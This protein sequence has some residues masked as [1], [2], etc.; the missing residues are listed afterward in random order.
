VISL[1]NELI[2]KLTT[3]L[4]AE[5][6]VEHVSLFGSRARG[7]NRENSDI[8]LAL[9]GREIPLSLYT[10]LRDSVGLYK[11]D[12]VNVEEVDNEDLLEEIQTHGQ[13]IYRKS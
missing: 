9:T 1:P 10:R 5:P 12:I 8:D 7:D 3:V 11:L 2:R 6:T 13:I 4:E